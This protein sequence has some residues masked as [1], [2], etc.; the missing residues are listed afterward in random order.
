LIGRLQSGR[1]GA[2][3]LLALLA[4]TA[5]LSP[6]AAQPAPGNEADALDSLV[7][8]FSSGVVA[9]V[10]PKD[11]K[12]ATKLWADMIMKRRG[13]HAESQAVI[14]PDLSDLAKRLRDKTIDLAFLLPQEFVRLRESQP[15]VPV[16]VSTPS[17]GTFEELLLLVRRD[18]GIRGVGDLRGRRLVVDAEQRGALP[19]LWLENLLMKEKLPGDPASV[20]V[21]IRGAHKPSQTVLPVF[22]GQAD[23]CI[24]T[25][26]AFGTM[27]ELNPQLGH[28][29]AVLAVSP[30]VV[31]AIGVLRREYE[32]RHGAYITKELVRLH[33]DPQGRQ[34]L[35]LFQKG[36]LIPYQPAYVA[37]VEAMLKEHAELRARETRKP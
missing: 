6:G 9:N 19:R 22:F 24:V 30:P 4:G 31:T 25:R 15:V 1:A 2:W 34:I 12:A 20:F 8:G 26:N 7:I 37:S 13:A 36:R 21:S 16:V 3:L 23:A 5:L 14:M 10:D 29:L 18:S 32:E 33:Q 27:A 17:N 11:A 35:L 28:D